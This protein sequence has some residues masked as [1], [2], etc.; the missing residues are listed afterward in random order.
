MLVSLFTHDFVE[1]YGYFVLGLD[2][3]PTILH[4]FL[5]FVEIWFKLCLERFVLLAPWLFVEFVPKPVKLWLVNVII[6]TLFHRLHLIGLL[7]DFGSFLLCNLRCNVLKT[8]MQY[9]VWFLDLLYDFRSKFISLS[10][11]VSNH[12]VFNLDQQLLR[13]A[14]VIYCFLSLSHDWSFHF[15]QVGCPCKHARC[16][17]DLTNLCFMN[18]KR[19]FD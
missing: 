19:F 11:W 9:L 15:G 13:L 12:P 17:F 7:S 4:L 2:C 6:E 14:W 8:T 5:N 3:P 10:F 16:L 1:T 18:C